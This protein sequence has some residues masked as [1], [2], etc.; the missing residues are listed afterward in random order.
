MLPSV[1][2]HST[3]LLITNYIVVLFAASLMCDMFIIEG[4]KDIHF[5]LS[6]NFWTTLKEDK[7]KLIHY[8]MW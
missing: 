5:F 3:V 2:H 8:D 6:V 1:Y 7:S 4:E